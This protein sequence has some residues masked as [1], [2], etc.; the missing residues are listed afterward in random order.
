VTAPPVTIEPGPLAA[1][2]LGIIRAGR[3]R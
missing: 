3:G 1:K 2:L